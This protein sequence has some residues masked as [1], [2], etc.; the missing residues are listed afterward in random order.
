MYKTTFLQ[1][2][3]LILVGIFL[4]ALII[5]VS[6]RTAGFLI[7]LMRERDN[8]ASLRDKGAYHI[9]CLGESTTALGGESSWPAQLETVLNERNSG[10]RFKVINGGREDI[11]TATISSTLENTLVKYHP[12]MVI[13]MT[14]INDGPR[15]VPHEYLVLVNKKPFFSRLRVY[16]LAKAIFLHIMNKAREMG[17]Y[18]TRVSLN[19]RV[20]SYADAGYR[21]KR[22]RKTE[23]MA[24]DTL[25]IDPNNSEV[26]NELGHLY[27]NLNRVREAEEMFKKALK[28]SPVMF[29]AYDGLGACYASQS[30]YG[31]AEEMFK[32]ALKIDPN[33]SEVYNELGRL[34][35]K[36]K[37]YHQA[38]V[39]FKKAM[40]LTIAESSQDNEI[41]ARQEERAYSE[42]EEAYRK[43]IEL[44]PLD[45]NK[46]IVLG[47]YYRE[48]E[49]Y[50]ESEKILKEAIRIA[51]DNARAY[52]E[53]GTCYI[54][55][56]RYKEQEKMFRKVIEINPSD[57]AAYC[58]LGHL[59]SSHQRYGEAEEM[60]KKAIELAPYEIEA[61]LGLATCYREQG[62]LE[63]VEELANLL[64]KREIQHDRIYG[65]IALSYL[66]EGQFK[67]AEIFI[68]KANEFRAK[69]YNPVT[70]YNYRRIKKIVTERGIKF[71]CMQYPMRSIE[72][73]KKIFDSNEDIIFVSNEKIFKEEL[74]KARYE[75]LFVD[76]FGGEF[77]HATARGNRLIAENLADTIIKEV[78]SK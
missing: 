18:K 74:K 42:T 21:S 14:G 60:F 64:R 24:L 33:N 31:E 25:K 40:S 49:R 4:C 6:L 10:I 12:D 28:I 51:P 7:I 20:S 30:R 26:Y 66:D 58:E 3:G 38:T 63:G 16:K 15:T 75:D 39:M 62:K 47:S 23:N 52:F 71:V 32:K 65:I 56:H 37:D 77:G 1:K 54:N 67:K 2:I 9:L 13:S 36:T 78:I 27:N 48:Q 55:Q 76:S 5:E 22:F 43:A 45:Y 50:A 17:I 70:Y 46:Y 68:K 34:Y 35:S 59:Y 11:D 29:S 41:D 44:T 61:Y 73:L 57:S 8:A 53:L 72:P 19:N 69:Y